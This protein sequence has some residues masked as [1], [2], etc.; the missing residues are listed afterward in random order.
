MVVFS[1]WS[2][3]W[4]QTLS[5]NQWAVQKGEEGGRDRAFSYKSLSVTHSC[6]NMNHL[7]TSVSAARHKNSKAHKIHTWK[8]N[9]ALSSF[10]GWWELAAELIKKCGRVSA[11]RK[12][13]ELEW[14]EAAGCSVPPPPSQKE[15]WP[16]REPSSAVRPSAV[17]WHLFNNSDGVSLCNWPNISCWQRLLWVA[18]M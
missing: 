6:A 18:N 7:K 14:W 11:W 1:L 2:C 8:T 15:T 3:H 12:V 5:Y 16:E 10:R 4:C 17:R 9:E 13:L